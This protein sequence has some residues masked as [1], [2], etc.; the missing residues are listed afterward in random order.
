M[1]CYF[2]EH[3]EPYLKKTGKESRT[4]N[5]KAVWSNVGKS[6][7]YP[8]W[9]CTIMQAPPEN[10]GYSHEGV[11][12]EENKRVMKIRGDT[13]MFTMITIHVDGREILSKTY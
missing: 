13:D 1:K 7:T 4:F 3:V 12:I 5:E 2:D 8:V 11:V 10:M 6:Y 9:G